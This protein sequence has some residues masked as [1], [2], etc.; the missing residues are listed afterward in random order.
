MEQTITI[1][2]TMLEKEGQKYPVFKMNLDGKKVDLRF[3]MDSNNISVIPNGVSKVIVENLSESTTSF[4]PR[5]YATFK[6]VAKRNVTTESPEMNVDSE[7][8]E[9]K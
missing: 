9:V 2:K 4:Y 7:T 3:R 8:G 6:E 1:L 5:Y